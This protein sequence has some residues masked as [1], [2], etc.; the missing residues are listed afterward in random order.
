MCPTT[1]ALND[2]VDN[3]LGAAVHSEIGRHLETCADC[4]L[5][6]AE[7]QQVVVA[8][9]SLPP[10]APPAYLWS[11]LE[12]QLDHS[13][14][15]ASERKAED[16]ESRA[17]G[18]KP[19]WL[20]A[21]AAALIATTFVG[22]RYAGLIGRRAQPLDAADTAL[23][24]ESE[25]REA[26]GHYQKAISGLQ[27]IA[28]AGRGTLDPTTAATLQKSLAVI[29]RAITE[30]RAAL[31]ADPGNASAQASLLEGLKATV[32]LLQDTVGLMSEL[33]PR[34]RG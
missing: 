2:Y 13:T 3:A 29:D 27:Q 23:S 34:S 20:L 26:E 5:V 6:V 33:R 24:V 8:A 1:E 31:Q 12:A 30:S 28:D 19:A 10:V 4:A 21:I 14:A 17:W 18:W 11:R 25:L 15:A 16:R 32:T 7:L 22:V 9:R